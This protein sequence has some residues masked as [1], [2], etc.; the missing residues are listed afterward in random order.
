MAADG[1]A[2]TG[3]VASLNVACLGGQC[4]WRVP[5][6]AELQTITPIP[7]S[8]DPCIDPIFG[9]TGSG[10]YWS[11]TDEPENP[12]AAWGVLFNDGVVTVRGKGG[13]H[14]VRAVRG[15]L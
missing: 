6:I 3:L 15:G 7:C 1:G 13:A 14:P 11:S 9:P 10:F 4:D 8:E 12:S 2:F 5:T